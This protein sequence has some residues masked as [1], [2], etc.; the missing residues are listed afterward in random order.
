MVMEG[1]TEEARVEVA[2]VVARVGAAR[3]EAQVG[4]TEVEE[5]EVAKEE[6]ASIHLVDQGAELEALL[7]V[8]VVVEVAGLVVVTAVAAA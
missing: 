4:A 8:S 3:V 1:G 5:M 6:V 7:A 2:K